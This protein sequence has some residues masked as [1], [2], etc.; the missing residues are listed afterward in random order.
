[1]LRAARIDKLSLAALEATLRLYLPPHDPLARI[2]VLRAIA[3]PVQTIMARAR[4]LAA[5]LAGCPGLAAEA[6]ETEAF[7]G[8]GAL[9][10]QALPSAAVALR[11]DTLSLETLA[12]QLRTGEPAVVGRISGDR[13][14]LDLRTVG[15]AEID[16][17]AGAVRGALTG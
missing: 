9:P 5:V 7:V 2:P 16:A 10:Q 15:E 8:G 4:A 3:T 6:V 11:A 17:L 14:L 13:L 1:M 12:G